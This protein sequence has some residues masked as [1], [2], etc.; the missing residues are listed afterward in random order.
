MHLVFDDCMRGTAEPGRA[1]IHLAFI[2]VLILVCLVP[3]AAHGGQGSLVAGTEEWP[4]YAYTVP[5]GSIQGM[6]TDIVR[7]VLGRMGVGLGELASY[8]WVR[9]L[10]LLEGGGLDLLY[11]AVYDPARLRFGRYPKTPLFLTQWVFFIR[12]QDAGKLRFRSMDDLDGRRVGVVRSYSY[13]P[14]FNRYLRSG[15]ESVEV[16]SDRANL[17]LLLRGRVDY[18]VLEYMNGLALMARDGL[19]GQ[20]VPLTGEPLGVIR[21]YPLFNR[22]NVSQD[23]V[24]RF[25]R[26]LAAF[27]RDKAYDEIVNRHLRRL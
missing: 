22:I 27:K 6:S 18:A 1:P 12:K 11:S 9:G 21:L 10:K 19:G 17:E 2:L 8:P 4:P 25:D 24:D 5:D 16:S 23:F 7:A 13:T 3:L 20:L 14:E 15:G 26:E